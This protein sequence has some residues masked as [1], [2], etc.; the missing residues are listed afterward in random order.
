VT[1][2][3]AV[4]GWPVGHSRSPALHNAAYRA[5]GVDAI[6]VALA[7]APDG[8]A[9]ALAGVRALGF[10]GVNITVPHK[11]AA[12]G[13]CDT[14]DHLAAH[15]G[16]VNTIVVRDGRL[17]GANTDVGG[18]ARALEEAGGA[19]GP[20]VLLGRGGSARAVAGALPGRELR[21]VVRPPVTTRF[22]GADAVYP[23]TEEGL[24]RALAGAGLVVDCTP[25]GLSPE[26]EGAL[27]DLPLDQLA[28]GALV[29]SLVY[30]R[31]PALLARAR[32]AGLRA[33][34]GAAMLIHQAALAFTLLTGLPAPLE[35]MRAAFQPTAR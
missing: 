22:V 17:V 1:R 31:E 8:L 10:L 11:Q 30:H 32:A 28:P 6:Y 14:T 19:T 7:V 34:D 24:A 15:I 13:L 18:F 21:V 25:T 29:A 12:L 3:A 26:A 9:D 4:L 27:A 35:V 33:M 23:W 20:A 16:A 2:L 5:L